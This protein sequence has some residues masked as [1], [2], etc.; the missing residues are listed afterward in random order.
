MLR[1][2][3]VSLNFST[4]L[5]Y[6]CVFR[7]FLFAR[8][9]QKESKREMYVPIFQFAKMAFSTSQKVPWVGFHISM[10]TIENATK[11][12]CIVLRAGVSF[13]NDIVP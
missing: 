6:R 3:F 1:Y 5:G 13:G 2:R 11:N 12:S 7:A 10:S 8:D 4:M 9:G